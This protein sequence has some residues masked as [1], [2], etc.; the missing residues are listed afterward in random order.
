MDTNVLI[1]KVFPNN[2]IKHEYFCHQISVGNFDRNA[3]QFNKIM[4]NFYQRKISSLEIF[5]VYELTNIS[6]Y[7]QKMQS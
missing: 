4:R 7:N 2:T 6:P 5:Y 1:C 3:K